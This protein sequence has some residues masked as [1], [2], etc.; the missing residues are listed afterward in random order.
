MVD[1][2]TN[3]LF[4][5]D[6]NDDFQIDYENAPSFEE[7]GLEPKEYARIYRKRPY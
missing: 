1:P 2:E 6:G 7:S 5:D 4:Y 3:E